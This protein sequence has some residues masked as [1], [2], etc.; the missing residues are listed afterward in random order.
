MAGSTNTTTT[1]SSNSTQT[2]SAKQD[3][4]DQELLE[5]QHR[6][7]AIPAHRLAEILMNERPQSIALVLSQLESH[8]G[9]EVLTYFT[10]DIQLDVL[11]RMT[12]SIE[13]DS[14]VIKLVT[15]AVLEAA[16]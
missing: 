10:S 7:R 13:T 8:Q 1:T 2:A 11:Q 12:A 6:L 3:T 14:E 5:I 4:N 16:A 9:R 15:H